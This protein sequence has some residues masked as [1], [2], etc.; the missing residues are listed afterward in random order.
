M[1]VYRLAC[2]ARSQKFRIQV[3]TETL[4]FCLILCFWG[5]AW[6]GF[7]DTNLVNHSDNYPPY[8]IL[9]EDIW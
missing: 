2:L 3:P 6:L 5:Q 4:R 7:Y 9:R 8:P 1:K